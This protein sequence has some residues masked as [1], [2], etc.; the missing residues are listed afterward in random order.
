MMSDPF[1]SSLVLSAIIVAVLGIGMVFLS[2]DL[3]F[4]LTTFGVF[5]LMAVMPTVF[6]LLSQGKNKC[7]FFCFRA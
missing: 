2:L 4:F 7:Q 3:C 1:I 6:S 5:R